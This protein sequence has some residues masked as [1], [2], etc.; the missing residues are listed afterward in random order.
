MECR[1]WEW[2]TLFGESS[3]PLG[4]TNSC[5]EKRMTRHC[6]SHGSARE[7]RK[8]KIHGSTSN[9]YDLVGIFERSGQN[10]LLNPKFAE[11]VD[12]LVYEDEN[13]FK[14]DETRFLLQ[15]LAPCEPLS[16]EQI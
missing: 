10:H 11:H 12:S 13:Y 15:L 14:V 7:K 6:L 3:A 9:F 4:R 8:K 5:S 1:R 16:N 2:D